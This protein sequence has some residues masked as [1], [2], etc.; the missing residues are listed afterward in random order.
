MCIRD[1]FLV[2]ATYY[3][4]LPFYTLFTHL[5]EE[6]IQQKEYLNWMRF[7]PL[8]WF[9]SGETK[10]MRRAA[11]SCTILPISLPLFLIFNYL[12]SIKVIGDSFSIFILILFTCSLGGIIGTVRNYRF[13][14]KYI[15]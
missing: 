13:S 12:Y 1:S 9:M 2:K 8:T 5:F 11:V 6:K 14:K 3:V 7:L 15:R 4:A 10:E